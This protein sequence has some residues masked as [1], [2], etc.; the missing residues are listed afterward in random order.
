MVSYEQVTDNVNTLVLDVRAN[1]DQLTELQS[2]QQRKEQQIAAQAAGCR[3][4]RRRRCRIRLAT[5]SRQRGLT[6]RAATLMHQLEDVLTQLA[7]AQGCRQ[8][9][10]ERREAEPARSMERCHLSPSPARR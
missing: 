7:T 10:W 8:R 6:G 3:P 5:S 1:A 9:H 4:S 2:Q